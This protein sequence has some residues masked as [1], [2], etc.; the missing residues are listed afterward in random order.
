MTALNTNFF[1]AVPLPDSVRM[2]MERRALQLKSELPFKSWTRPGDY[3]ITLV[4]LGKGGFKQINQLKKELVP[5]IGRHSAYRITVDQ[6]GTFGKKQQPRVL[7][8]GVS[9]DEAMDDL[10]RDLHN[11]CAD[12]GFNLDDRPFKP[13]ITLARKWDSQAELDPSK[14]GNTIDFDHEKGSWVANEVALYQT[15]PNQI[16]QYQALKLFSLR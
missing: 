8:A 9:A 11:R 3:H 10:Q 5:V 7:W 16:P 15:H 13:H 2:F 1:L 4:F 14:L 6:I 12:L